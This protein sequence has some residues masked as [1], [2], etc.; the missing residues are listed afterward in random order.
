MTDR[1]V[2]DSGAVSGRVLEVADHPHA[3][4][5]W[6]CQVDI[7][8]GHKLGIVFGGTYRV[9]PGD[10]VPVAPPGARLSSG[11]KMRT[12]S[13]RG[14]RSEGMLCSL[15]ELG[16]AVGGPDAVAILPPDMDPGIPLKTGNA[17]KVYA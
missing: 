1:V 13:Y 17:Q 5:L 3:D 9:R 12:R 4:R 15:D 2:V 14:R 11:K 16:W 8:G 10:N 7:G 6:Q